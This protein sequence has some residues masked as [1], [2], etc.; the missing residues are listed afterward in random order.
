MEVLK[1]EKN[2]LVFEPEQMAKVRNPEDCLIQF[3]NIQKKSVET[4]E[5]VM[6]DGAH[7][8]IG[9]KIVTSGIL[10]RTLVHP[11]E[12]FRE[13]IKKNAAAIIAGHNH[14][15]GTVEPSA[16][17]WEITKRLKEAG[18]IIGIPVLDHIIISKQGYYSFL[19]DGTL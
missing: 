11:R 17:D 3:K 8:I 10:N 4:F 5:V 16:E 15:S 2:V 6:L 12:I 7:N 1:M 14:P 18:E 9:K 13:A 19:E